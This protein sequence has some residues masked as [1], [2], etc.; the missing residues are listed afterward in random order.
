MGWGIL[1]QILLLIT[2]FVVAKEC[3]RCLHDKFFKVCKK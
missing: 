2:F 3:A 1:G